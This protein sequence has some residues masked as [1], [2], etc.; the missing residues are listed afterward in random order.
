MAALM[1]AMHRLIKI[2]F[3]VVR[4]GEPHRGGWVRKK[5]RT[6]I[7]GWD[8]FCNAAAWG[9]TE[10]KMILSLS[11]KFT[12]F[13]FHG[14]KPTQGESCKQRTLNKKPLSLPFQPANSKP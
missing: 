6:R 14:G 1:A 9:Q 4:S 5:S 10:L 7:I 2:A 13:Y 12:N 3:G 11:I 8:I